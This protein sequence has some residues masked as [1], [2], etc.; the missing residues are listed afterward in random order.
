MLNLF[1]RYHIRAY[2]ELV[3]L[4][5]LIFLNFFRKAVI[6]GKDSLKPKNNK[7]LGEEE[8]DIYTAVRN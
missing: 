2:S 8:K 1:T 7:R 4:E 3:K 6:K 5:G